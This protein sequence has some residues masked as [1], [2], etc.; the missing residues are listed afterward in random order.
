MS[1]RQIAAWVAVTALINI[2]G[3]SL[4]WWLVAS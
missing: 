4:L 3:F 2:A 1:Y